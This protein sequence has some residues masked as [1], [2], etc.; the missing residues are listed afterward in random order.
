MKQDMISYLSK[1]KLDLKILNEY[2]YNNPEDSYKEKNSYE[3]ICNFLDN[4]DFKIQKKFLDLKTSFY[5]SK[6]LGHPK[7]C[8]LCEYDSIPNEGHLTGHNLL[9]STSI[10]AAL[11][12]GNLVDKIGGSVVLIGCPGEYLGGTKALM[13]KQGVFDDI[14]VVLMAHPDIITSESGTSSA[15]IPMEVKFL[16]NSGLSFLNRGVY[17]SLDGIL[18]TFNTLNSIIK[19]FPEDVE[20][21]SI[22]SK[23]GFTPLLIPMESEAKFYIRSKE[24]ELAKIVE[25]K[26]REIVIYTSK[27]IRV[28]YRI[29]LYEPENEELITNRTLNRLFSHNLK[30][31]GIINIAEARDIT[32]G[33]S[34]GV[35]SK[36]VPTIHPYFSIIKENSNIKY[37]TKEFSKAT[38][39]DY[40]FEEAMKVALALAYTGNDLIINEKLLVD[41]KNEFYKK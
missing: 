30:E 7:I 22:L 34:L 6:G 21:N 2:L 41:V 1:C 23:G 32:S 4:Y 10:A 27:L 31:N 20:V 11:T 37:G 38:I 5:A 18:L 14:D 9:T 24:M 40:A 15:I 8:F 33:L 19:G 28:Q 39:S 16:G 25:N 26:I 36:N 12:L 35:V 13:A 3:H 17:T 29:S